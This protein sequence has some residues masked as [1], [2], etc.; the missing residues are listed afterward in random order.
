MQEENL[1]QDNKAPVDSGKPTVNPNYRPFTI[2][3]WEGYGESNIDDLFNE[4]EIKKVIGPSKEEK[5]EASL[6]NEGNKIQE[7]ELDYYF[8]SYSGFGIHEDM[9]RDSVRT[10]TYE[11]AICKNAHLFKDKIV[12]DVGCGTGILSMF[13]A[14]AGAKHVYGI[15]MADIHKSVN[16]FVIII[17]IGN[18]N[19]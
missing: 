1:K 8:K 13:A 6:K 10:K 16:N 19:C 4:E 3:N 14:R 18:K 5:L 9:L 15:E 2:R 12:L 17:Y 7:E 11:N